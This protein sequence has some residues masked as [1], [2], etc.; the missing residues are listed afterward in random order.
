M[1]IQPGFFDITERAQPLTRMDDPLAALNAR[2]DWEAFCMALN[3][4]HEKVRKSTGGA[5]PID[6]ELKTCAKNE[7]RLSNQPISN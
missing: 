6:V 3:R 2:I 5:K 1:L 4:V 7:S